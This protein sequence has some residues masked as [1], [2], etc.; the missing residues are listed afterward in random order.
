MNK[1]LIAVLADAGEGDD[2]VQSLA[3]AA[4]AAILEHGGRVLL[5]ADASVRVPAILTAGEYLRPMEVETTG[6]RAEAPIVLAPF[7][8]EE[9]LEERLFTSRGQ[10]EEG[11][12]SLLSELLHAGLVESGEKTSFG[13]ALATHRPR[14]ILIIGHSMRLHELQRDVAQYHHGEEQSRVFRLDRGTHA[15]VRDGWRDVE[16]RMARFRRTPPR[17]EGRAIGDRAGD[18]DALAHLAAVAAEDAARVLAIE[19]AIAELLG[20][21]ASIA[22]DY[23]L[24]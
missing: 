6:G 9:S 13:E 12:P 14:A 8:G 3:L 16:D 15:N 20:D 19:D 1:R 4:V 17:F 10:D 2:E 21:A 5:A 18:D 7:P 22:E 23:E 24:R 11:A